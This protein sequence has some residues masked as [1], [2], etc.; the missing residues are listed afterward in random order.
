[1]AT[2]RL[3]AAV[4][5]SA[6]LSASVYYLW[7]VLTTISAAFGRANTPTAGLAYSLCVLVL[8]FVTATS[9]ALVRG[10]LAAS[11]ATLVYYL[12]SLALRPLLDF[13]LAN[14]PQSILFD[15]WGV[16]VLNATPMFT[17]LEGFCSLLTIQA[18]GKLGGTGIASLI[19]SSC[20]ISS[21][22]W[23]VFKLYVQWP[24]PVDS[25]QASMLGSVLTLLTL[26]GSH[27]IS[28]NRASPLEV[29]LL[30]AY[31]VKCLYEVFPQ[32]NGGDMAKMVEYIIV[33]T[34]PSFWDV[35]ESTSLVVLLQLGYRI[36]VFFAATKIIPLLSGQNRPS[37]TIYWVY[38]YSPLVVIAVY[39]NLMMQQSSSSQE[40]LSP[41]VSS[42]VWNWVNI[43]VVLGLYWNELK[44]TDS[45]L[46]P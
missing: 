15:Y 33:S 19:I 43:G 24:E 39:T 6:R 5:A 41:V 37:G 4:M 34:T 12:Q 38:L 17:L 26:L 22:I 10:P 27:A 23:F 36:V 32:L 40:M 44:Y 9:R 35:I 30:I 7:V 2:R 14:S 16:F 25:L 21:C 42:A 3:E 46:N 11:V 28:S 29:S 13:I 8:Y 1:M 31:I 20:V 18:V 45:S